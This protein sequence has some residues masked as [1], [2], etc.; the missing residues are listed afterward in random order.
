[1]EGKRPVNSTVFSDQETQEILFFPDASQ[2]PREV[3]VLHCRAHQCGE[4]HIPVGNRFADKP[5]QEVAQ[6][7]ILTLIPKKAVSLPK[8]SPGYSQAD[9]KLATYLKAQKREGGWLV[10]P[11]NQITVSPKWCCK[12]SR[13]NTSKPTGES[14]LWWLVQGLRYQC[15]YDKNCQVC[16]CVLKRI[17]WIRKDCLHGSLIEETP[18]GITGKLLFL[19]WHTSNYTGISWYYLLDTLSRW[20]E[21]FP[22]CTNKAR[23]VTKVLLKEIIPWL[24]VPIGMSLIG[25]PF[26]IWSVTATW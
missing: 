5:A 11:N 16:W 22:C 4:S 20:P 6:Q 15:P 1:M 25:S 2:L 9:S 10:T 3:S 7:G 18:P 8:V 14:V 13:R 19:S 24:G 12:L 21:F 26:Y 23:K 17:L